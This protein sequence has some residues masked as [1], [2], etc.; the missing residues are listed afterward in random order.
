MDSWWF[1]GIRVDSLLNAL[2]FRTFAGS[3][4]EFSHTESISELA[5]RG[6]IAE[7]HPAATDCNGNSKDSNIAGTSIVLQYLQE[8]CRYYSIILFN[9]Y[10]S[11]LQLFMAVYGSS[12]EYFFGTK[13]VN[14][15]TGPDA[16]YRYAWIF[17]DMLNGATNERPSH[18]C[19][20]SQHLFGH[21]HP[22]SPP[23]RV[24]VFRAP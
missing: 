8:I 18:F 21:H 11:H 4:V 14:T 3:K 20:A 6:R 23:N 19:R 9:Q 7:Q 17:D 13:P 2:C 1:N 10:Q 24:E 16:W 22:Y 5:G 15:N 12:K